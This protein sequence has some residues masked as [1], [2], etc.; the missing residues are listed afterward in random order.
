MKKPDG[1]CLLCKRP[2]FI[3]DGTTLKHTN[4]R[5]LARERIHLYTFRR[6][7]TRSNLPP[8]VRICSYCVR[9]LIS[10]ENI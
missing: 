4:N 7:M 5:P 6:T 10:V 9:E 8:A 1:R 2:G 3:H